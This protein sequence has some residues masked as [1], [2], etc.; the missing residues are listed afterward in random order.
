MTLVVK[1]RQIS[2]LVATIK[3]GF[4]LKTLHSH[5]D[6]EEIT[7]VLEGKGDY[8]AHEEIDF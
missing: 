4:T 7:Y 8:I 2:S 3:P 1:D 6:I 5:K